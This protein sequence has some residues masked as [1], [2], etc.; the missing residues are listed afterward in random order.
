LFRRA[1]NMDRW[2]IFATFVLRFTLK[3]YH[4]SRMQIKTK[5]YQLDAK[6]YTP[7]AFSNVLKAWWWVWLIPVG[8]VAL[9]GI[10]AAIWSMAWLW[11]GIGIAVLAV[12]LYILFW[13]L[14]VVA[15]TQHEKT[16]SLFDKYTYVITSQ[17]ILLMIDEKRGSPIPWERV[18]KVVKNDEAYI[19]FLSKVEFFYLPFRIFPAESQI[20]VF[21][22]ILK[23]KG[24]L[25]IKTVE[26]YAKKA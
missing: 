14:Q 25:T 8:I 23:R 1:I 2:R 17:Q 11:W 4:S 22:N 5:K 12:G 16:K 19:L 21:E 24:F 6:T 3:F 10:F 9:F 7:I 20:K 15:I 26:T 13:Y 18:I